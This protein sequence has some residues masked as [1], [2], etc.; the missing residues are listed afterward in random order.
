[1]ATE[2]FDLITYNGNQI[3]LYSENNNDYVNLTDL[4]K[5]WR[6]RKSIRSWMRNRATIA[7]LNAWEKKNNP[8]F[9]GVQMDTIEEVE[10]FD[11]D[12]YASIKNWVEKTH[13]IGIFTSKGNPSGTYAHKD[14]AIKFAGWL[15]PEFELYLI[16]K[17]QELKELERKKDSFELLNH[18]QILALVRLKEVFKYVAHQ[19]L[20]EDAHKE[21]FAAQ[22]GYSNPF[23]EFNNWRNKIL[24]ISVNVINERIR[25]YCIENKIAVTNK[26]LNKSKR[27]KIILLDSYESVRNAVW[28]FLMVKGEVNALNLAN[29]VGDMIRTEKGEILRKNETDLFNDKQDLGEYSD[30]EKE[31]GNIN[32]VKKAREVLAI[33]EEQKKK[34]LGLPNSFSQQLKGL[35]SVPPPKKNK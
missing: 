11:R 1:M 14:I 17:I 33:R 5:A 9:Q 32:M 8:K 15:S 24:D 10:D 25:Q 31:I 2:K 29:L 21:V 6:V 20:I 16:E 35:L 34:D 22:S 19:E 30:F 27:D 7:F 18:E 3:N 28:D 23:A 4:A 12:E 26:I 13:A